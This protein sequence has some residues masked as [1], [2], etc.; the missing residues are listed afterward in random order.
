MATDTVQ[1]GALTQ[2]QLYWVLED[3]TNTARAIERF[4][5]NL[6]E[7]DDERDG[8][9][10]RTAVQSLSQRIGLLSERAAR[11]L[12][13]CGG[14]SVGYEAEDWMLPPVFHRAAE[15]EVQHV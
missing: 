1:R 2:A 7:V 14:P 4:A 11:G 15:T 13:G 3:I 10:M 6:C 12:N 8:E 5:I 9:A